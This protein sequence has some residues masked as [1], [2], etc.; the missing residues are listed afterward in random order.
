MPGGPLML[1]TR[2]GLRDRKGRFLPALPEKAGSLKMESMKT[3]STVKE[4]PKKDSRLEKSASSVRQG[5]LMDLGRGRGT[6]GLGRVSWEGERVVEEGRYSLGVA[7]GAAL[8]EEDVD[9]GIGS[10]ETG[11]RLSL[12][13][14]RGGEEDR[15]ST[16]LNS[17]H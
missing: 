14:R 4:E 3:D 10:T 7:R 8:E 1:L 6:G 15:K 16:R 12:D 13:R 9:E 2:E 5:R 11:C 17:S